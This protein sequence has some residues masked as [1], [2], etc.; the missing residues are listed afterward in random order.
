MPENEFLYDERV[1]LCAL[2]DEHLPLLT[3]WINTQAVIRYLGGPLGMSIESERAWLERMRA[4]SDDVIYGVLLR[5]EQRL[6]GTVALHGVRGLGRHAEY[7]ISIGEPEFWGQ[8]YGTEA[9]RLIL[10]W[11]FN[12]LNL[13]SIFLRVFADNQRG[14]RSYEKV[15]FKHAGMLRQHAFRD[16][17]YLD[18]YYMDILRDEFNALWADWRQSQHRRYHGD[19][20]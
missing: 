6:I 19:P 10:D 3:R 5:S 12:R 15:G 16:G 7:G 4:S 14:V 18:M 1:A 13:N 9:C 17:V 8:G 20:A 11:G 2:S